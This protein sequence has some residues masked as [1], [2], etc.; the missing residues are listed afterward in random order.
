MN[1]LLQLTTNN[2]DI[3]TL[4]AS[5][6]Y[7][8]MCCGMLTRAWINYICWSMARITNLVIILV[9]SF[10][11]ISLNIAVGLPEVFSS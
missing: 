4:L 7:N 5:L 1:G 3:F 6:L 2:P 10:F 9:S 11:F 8:R